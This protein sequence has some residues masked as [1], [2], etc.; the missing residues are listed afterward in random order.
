MVDIIFHC[1]FM[2]C[3]QYMDFLAT[4]ASVSAWHSDVKMLSKRKVKVIKCRTSFSRFSQE[5][6]SHCL[7]PENWFA[8]CLDQ[9][10]LD[11]C[12]KGTYRFLKLGSDMIS[13]I[14]GIDP[15]PWTRFI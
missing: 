5:S 12:L 9:Q 8:L 13:S 6:E 2:H 11:N 14:E 3:I 10:G 7:P 4:P 1:V 15:L